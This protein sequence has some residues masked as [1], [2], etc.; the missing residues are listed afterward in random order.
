[1]LACV[2]CKCPQQPG[3]MFLV[4]FDTEKQLC[5]P[6]DSLLLCPRSHTLE[7]SQARLAFNALLFWFL[8]P[9]PY[10][11][12][13]PTQE[14]ESCSHTRTLIPPKIFILDS[15]SSPSPPLSLPQAADQ[16]TE[17]DS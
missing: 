9:L 14:N 1:M 7:L 17:A 6:P 16:M 5:G 15:F 10:S 12:K 3:S 8:T 2:K 4:P 11:H 13:N